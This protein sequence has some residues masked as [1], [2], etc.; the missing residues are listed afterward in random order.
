MWYGHVWS[1]SVCQLHSGAWGCV[2]LCTGLQEP[3]QEDLWTLQGFIPSWFYKFAWLSGKVSLTVLKSVFV[4]S[5]NGQGNWKGCTLILQ[6]LLTVLFS[7]EGALDIGKVSPWFLSFVLLSFDFSNCFGFG[8]VSHSCWKFIVFLC[9]V[10][11]LG[12]PKVSYALWAF[13]V[14]FFF[15]IFPKTLLELGRVGFV[16]HLLSCISLG[17]LNFLLKLERSQIYFWN[18]EFCLW[19]PGGGLLGNLAGFHTSCAGIL[20]FPFWL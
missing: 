19:F 15:C 20:Q 7:T 1:F 17:L 8:G 18:S 12:N 11:L 13:W 5:W 9:L 2:E 3:F 4:F 6:F 14:W 10:K 16:L